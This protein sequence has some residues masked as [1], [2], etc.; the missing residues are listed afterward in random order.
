M[1]LT[2]ATPAS[3]KIGW[4]QLK[5]DIKEAESVYVYTRMFEYCKAV[6]WDILEAIKQYDVYGEN[7]PPSYHWAKDGSKKLFIN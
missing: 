5:R 6:K 4:A 3:N 7:E 1:T 2:V